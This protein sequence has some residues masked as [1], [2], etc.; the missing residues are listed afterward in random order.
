MSIGMKPSR[1]DVVSKG[2]ELTSPLPNMFKLFRCKERLF[3]VLVQ[4]SDSNPIE[5]FENRKV[6]K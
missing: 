2:Q 3:L 4:H 5:V 6:T 1:D